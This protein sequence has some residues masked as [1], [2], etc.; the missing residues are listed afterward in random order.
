MS[1]KYQNDDVTDD[2]VTEDELD[3]EEDDD[4]EDEE[5]SPLETIV[6][7][8]MQEYKQTLNNYVADPSSPE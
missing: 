8:I 5:E 6:K 7:A 1:N 2:D 3:E 4:E